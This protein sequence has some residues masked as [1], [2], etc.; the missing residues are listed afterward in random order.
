MQL[1]HVVKKQYCQYLNLFRL[2][3]DIHLLQVIIGDS[4]ANGDS[5][6]LAVYFRI[7]IMV[8]GGYGFD[9]FPA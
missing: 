1:S 4:A 5:C 6:I 9:R 7:K 2:L 8:L 3:L